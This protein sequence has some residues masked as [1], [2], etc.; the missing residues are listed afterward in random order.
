MASFTSISQTPLSQIASVAFL[1]GV[2]F[3]W[4]ISSI[5]FEFEFIMF[6]FLGLMTL[7]FFLAVSTFAVSGNSVSIATGKASFVAICFSTGLGASIVFYRVFLHRCGKFNGPFQARITKF[8]A[9]YRSGKNVQFRKELTKWHNQYGDFVRTGPRQLSILR[10]SAI[11]LLYGPNPA[12]TKSSWYGQSGNDPNKV[13]INMTRDE[14]SY[15]LRR[16]A[17]DRGLSFKAISTYEPRIKSKVDLLIEKLRKTAGTPIDVTQMTMFFAFDLMGELGFSKTFGNLESGVEHLA[18]QG[19]HKHIKMLGVLSEV[20]WLLNLL[21]CIPGAAAGFVDFFDFCET[22]MNEK[23]KLE[24][25]TND[26]PKDIAS[27]LLKPVKEKDPSASPTSESLTDDS[28]VVIIAGSDTTA[29]TLAVILYYLAKNP[30]VQRKLRYLLQKAIPEGYQSWSYDKVK[31]VSYIT[32]IINEALRLKPPVMQIPPRETPPAGIHVDE[33][34]VPGNINVSI[35]TFTIMR[36]ERWWKQGNSFIPERFG[37]RME[38]LGTRN[39]PFLPFSMGTHMCPGNNLAY[40]SLR[41]SVSAI[42]LNFEVDFAE[43]ETGNDF[44]EEFQ[45]SALILLPPLKLIFTEIA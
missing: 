39:A 32:E 23:K 44:D 9:M 24:W 22:E 30:N 18:I 14:K 34:F 40:T 12:C 31:S 28:R 33:V 41:S 3:H 37:D 43:E 17:W 35:P 2:I 16:R 7:N 11:P 21:G 45:D 6:H 19:I 13:S 20:P 26:L 38:E 27:W 42:F 29:N 36:D 15:R 25:K 1:L 8:Y 5:N 4:S 10:P